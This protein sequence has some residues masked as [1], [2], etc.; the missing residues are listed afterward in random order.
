MNKEDEEKIDKANAEIDRVNA[1]QEEIED[2]KPAKELITNYENW[3]KKFMT[4]AEETVILANNSTQID[5]MVTKFVIMLVDS[6]CKHV[7][8][9]GFRE[10]LGLIDIV[11]YQLE[12]IH[13]DEG[14][15]DI[16]SKLFSK[17]NK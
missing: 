7:H 2:S 15:H 11:R 8:L 17:M 5:S 4:F 1:L 10:K 14:R 3:L 13:E 6:Y 16:M 12:K 9:N